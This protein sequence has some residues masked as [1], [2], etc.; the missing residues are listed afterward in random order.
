MRQ[1]FFAQIVHKEKG[2]GLIFPTSHFSDT[3]SVGKVKHFLL[4]FSDISFFRQFFQFYKNY[5]HTYKLLKNQLY[6]HGCKCT[7]T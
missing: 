2:G 6:E 7:Q 5:L 4:H 1:C 3:I